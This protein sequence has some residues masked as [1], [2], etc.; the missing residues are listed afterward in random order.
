[1]MFGQNCEIFSRLN[2]RNPHISYRYTFPEMS[3]RAITHEEC[4]LLHVGT[5][6]SCLFFCLLIDLF[7]L[8]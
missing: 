4:F 1:M 8:I 3:F 2:H 7:L 6:C 5:T